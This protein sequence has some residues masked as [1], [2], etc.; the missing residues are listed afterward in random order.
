MG[1][2]ERQWDKGEWKQTRV[3]EF[4]AGI[5]YVWKPSKIICEPQYPI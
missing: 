3:G 4:A 5:F 1:I 2:D